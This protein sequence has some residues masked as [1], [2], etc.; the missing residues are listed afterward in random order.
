MLREYRNFF[1][2][3]FLM[4][5]LFCD[6]NDDTESEMVQRSLDLTPNLISYLTFTTNT[7]ASC[8]YA[9]N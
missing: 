5:H 1:L 6:D 4:T 3:P 2:L 9:R 8:Y 7:L